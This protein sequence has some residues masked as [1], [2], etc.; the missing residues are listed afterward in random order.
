VGR[1][2]L[3]WGQSSRFRPITTF[4]A[5]AYRR[6]IIRNVRIVVIIGS[7]GKTT[8]ARAVATGLGIP[9]HRDISRNANVQIAKALLRIRP[10][11]SHGVIEVGVSNKGQMRKYARMVKPDMV[12]VTSIASEH[13]RSFKTLDATREEKSDMVRAVPDSGRV[14]LNGDDP[15]VLWMAQKT[16]A[17]VVTYGISPSNKCYASDIEQRWPGG[18]EFK[19]HTDGEIY[20]VR[21]RLLGRH[22]VYPILAAAAVARGEGL[23]LD[24]VIQRISNME[25]TKGRM[26]PVNLENGAVIIRDEFKSAQETI[27]AALH[28]F[29]DIPAERK[30]VVLGEVNEPLGSVSEL[31]RDIGENIGKI[32]SRAFFLGH[33]KSCRNY[34]VGAKQGGLSKDDAVHMGHDILGVARVLRDELGRGDVV[35]VKG[36]T[37]QRLLRI[38]LMLEG[39]LVACDLSVCTYGSKNC[40]TC[41]MLSK[42]WPGLPKKRKK[43]K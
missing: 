5:F 3:L 11:N 25:P 19:I 1:R 18:M 7:L 10:G 42:K 41:P 9:V 28:A 43:K 13:N 17:R 26:Q 37:E 35:L 8:T 39:M 27:Y 33:K 22:M 24:H 36:R 38:S 40:R 4:L 16:R 6:I 2:E 31:Y 29:S 12:V 20:E 23:E 32:A 21:S 15:N 30:I 34:V 14:F